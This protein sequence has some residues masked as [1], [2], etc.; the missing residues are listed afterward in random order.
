MIRARFNVVYDVSK[1]YTTVSR[2]YIMPGV[3]IVNRLGGSTQHFEDENG[4]LIKVNNVIN[5][6]VKL[7]QFTDDA[8]TQIV[9]L[10]KKVCWPTGFLVGI[11]TIAKR[12]LSETRKRS[13][14][15]AATQSGAREH[16]PSVARTRASRADRSSSEARSRY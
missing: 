1:L 15:R 14:A 10:A 8:C 12:E 11:V 3:G 5:D 4:M 13:K 6:T 2:Q 7:Q 9:L 16:I